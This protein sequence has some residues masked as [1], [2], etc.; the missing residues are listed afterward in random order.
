M[1]RLRRLQLPRRHHRQGL[2]PGRLPGRPGGLLVRDLRRRLRGAAPRRTVL[3]AARRPG[4]PAEGARHHHD[5]DVGG[6]L[7]H[8]GHP[9]LRHHRHRRPAAAPA[10][11]DGPGLLHRRRVRRRH[12]LRCRVRARPQARLPVQ[13]ARLRH[14]RRLRPRLG[15]RH[16]ARPAADR[17]PDALLGLARALPDR[18]AARCDRPVHAAQ[19]GGV[20]GLPAAAG[21]AR[22]GAG[23]GVDG[24]RAEGHR[25]QP[26][27]AAAH[28]HG[29]GAAVQRH[30]LHGHRLPAHLPDRDAAP[31]RRLRGPPGAHRHG[32][33][34]RPDHLPRPAQRPDRTAA[35]VR[36]RRG[37]DDRPGRALLPAAQGAGHLAAGARGADPVHAAGLLRRAE[38]RHPA[39]AVPDGGALRG[40]GHRLQHRGRGLRRHHPAGHRRTRRGDRGQADARLLPDAGRSHRTA[41]RQVPARECPGAVEGVAADGRLARRAARTDHRLP[42]VVRTRGGA[43]TT[44]LNR[45]G[46]RA[47]RSYE[48]HAGRVSGL[49]GL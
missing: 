33:D 47:V 7:R 2:L 5:H 37:R 8:R 41:H 36:R 32:V 35:G 20:P 40:H 16:G 28:L 1:V 17:R 39:G 24:Q 21:R 22:E 19:A 11:P 34:R 48:V 18:R 13:L 25:P 30:Q 6:H 43:H 4:R 31:L 12:H 49:R 42:G 23:A 38:R 44:R 45:A 3:R 27:A 46:R 26:L 29:P 9:G 15:P 10:G 14:L